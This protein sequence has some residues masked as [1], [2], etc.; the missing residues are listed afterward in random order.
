[1]SGTQSVDLPLQSSINNGGSS[2]AASKAIL[3][4]QDKVKTLEREN[5]F[6]REIVATN[7]QKN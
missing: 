7:E 5:G 4:L 1:M 2:A 3:A 6:L